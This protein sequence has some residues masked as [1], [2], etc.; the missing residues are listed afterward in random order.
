[1]RSRYGALGYPDGATSS[2]LLVGT[3][4]RALTGANNPHAPR[5]TVE[6]LRN[7]LMTAALRA[8]A[9]R[10]FE[11][12]VIARLSAAGLDETRPQTVQALLNARH[13]AILQRILAAESQTAAV[14]LTD[15][16]A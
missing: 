4:V 7:G 16:T 8:G 13:P 5:I 2:S 12:G 3:D 6:A 14:P 9:W 10:V 15:A 11:A 1:M